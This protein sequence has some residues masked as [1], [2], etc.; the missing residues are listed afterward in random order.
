MSALLVRNEGLATA[1]ARFHHIFLAVALAAGG[2]N[3][4]MVGPGL[5]VARRQQLMRTP[6][7][8]RT[9]GSGFVAFGG[10]SMQAVI[11][12]GLLIGVAGGAGNFKGS[13]FVGGMF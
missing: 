11:E 4:C 9:C 1:P 13:G 12:G 6:V 7:A 5:G 10:G 2:G 8:I 3:I